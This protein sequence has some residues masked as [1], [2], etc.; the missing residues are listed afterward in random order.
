M[1]SRLALSPRFG[2]KL[3]EVPLG[4]DLPYWVDDERFHLDDHVRRVAVPAPGGMKELTDLAGYLFSQPLDRSRPLW[5]LWLIEGVEGGRA[6]L[7]MKL[8][9]C[10]MDGVSGAG[11]AE[12]I[13]D[14]QPEPAEAPLLPVDRK[15]RAGPGPGWSD[16]TRRGIANALERPRHLARHLGRFGARAVDSLRRPE[17]LPTPSQVPRASFNGRIGRRRALACAEISFESVKSLRKHFDATVNDVV[18]AITGGALRLALAERGELPDASL[19]ALVPMST[20]QEGD[21]RPGNQITEFAVSW[22]T[23]VADPEERLLRIRDNTRLAKESTRSTG[24]NLMQACGESLP[25]GV[26][27]LLFRASQNASDL[28]VPGNAV[29]SNVRG[30]PV[31]LY[32][33]GARVEG[34]YPLSI[35]APT[36]GLNI[37]VVSY[38]GR[39]FFGF[40]VD[41]DLVPEPW[42]IADA[43]APALAELE[44]AAEARVHRAP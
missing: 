33:A 39:V 17:A 19:V 32:I 3:R 15:E 40:T 41:P 5:E 36:Q 27:H 16:I 7:L 8:H 30:T 2:W 35:L 24:A 34:M 9:H 14:L 26:F 21:S 22:S 20:R 31:P 42:R 10:L 25:P 44:A 37:T 18:L 4:L 12:L 23:D 1:G 13:C 28:P 29:V 6:A 43:I 11:L 38:C